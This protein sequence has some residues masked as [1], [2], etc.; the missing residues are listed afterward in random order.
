M[1]KQTAKILI[2]FLVVAVVLVSVSLLSAYLKRLPKNPP[3]TVGN[4]AGNINNNGIFCEADGKIYF[5]NAYDNGCLYVMNAD[6]GNLQKLS[7]SSASLINSGGDYLYYYQKSVDGNKGLGYV[8]SVSGLCRM[9]NDGSRITGMNRSVIFSM[10]LV[11]NSIYYLSSDENGPLFYKT[12]TDGK[13]EV[14]LANYSINPACVS[15]GL[16]YYN[17][18]LDN[19]Y[20]YALNTQSDT[21]EEIWRGNL[22]YPIIEGNYVYYLDVANNYRLC[23][24][25]R[26][27]D[28]IEVLTEDR[29]DCYNL[30]GGYIYYQKNSEA[31]P[32]LMRMRYDGS[33]PEVIAEGNYTNINLTSEYVYFQSFASPV[34]MYRTPTAGAVNVTTFDEAM[35]AAL[36]NGTR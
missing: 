27:T 11:G 35:E 14:L 6:G 24:Y 33:E 32:A 28:V 4:T 23:R 9:R 10:Q 21:A 17:G 18:T 7:S 3:E 15:D 25:D 1:K 19:H 22:W 5:S 29:V 13:E 30:G 36:K 12:S 2:L 16:I 34:P 26:A 8:R 20:L 31:A